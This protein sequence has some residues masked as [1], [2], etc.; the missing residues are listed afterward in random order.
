MEIHWISL[1]TAEQRLAPHLYAHLADDGSLTRR[2]RETCPD[3][4][5]VRL[6]DHHTVRPEQTE[7]ELLDLQADEL[8]LARQVFLC[9]D[10]MPRVYAR[11]IIG[12]VDRNRPLTARIERLGQQ[13]LGSILFRDPLAQKR[14]MHLAELPLGHAFFQGIEVPGRAPTDM[15]W[16]RRSLY[17]YEGCELIVYEAFVNFDP[18]AAKV[19]KT[20]AE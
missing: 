16:I 15:A 2:V 17:D 6:I 19:P 1:Q 20:A 7:R 12:L 5:E 11:T 9:C 13:S 3:S 14:M 8:A 4:F 10:N 18:V